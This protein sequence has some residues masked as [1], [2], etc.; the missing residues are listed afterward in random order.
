MAERKSSSLHAGDI[1]TPERDNQ[2]QN[3]HTVH[4]GKLFAAPRSANKL[5]VV[6]ADLDAFPGAV[7]RASLGESFTRSD[8]L[9]ALGDELHCCLPGHVSSTSADSAT[10]ASG[11]INAS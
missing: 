3:T 4:G 8:I 9:E 11:T 10:S 2:W 1:F 6:S 5:L 7:D